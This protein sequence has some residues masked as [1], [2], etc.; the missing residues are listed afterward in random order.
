M[1]ADET[2]ADVGLKRQALAHGWAVGDDRDALLA[3]MVAIVKDRSRK[4]RER[5]AAYRAICMSER[6]GLRA[7][8]VAM[9]AEERE[10]VLKELEELR[11]IVESHAE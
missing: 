4:P 7:L 1:D 10:Q 11:Q 3:E 9:Q 5:T 2:R 6:I 8:E